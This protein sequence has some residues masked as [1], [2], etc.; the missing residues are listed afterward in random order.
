MIKKPLRLLAVIALSLLACNSKSTSSVTIPAN[1][2][3]NLESA[4]VQNA[5]SAPQKQSTGN[6]QRLVMHQFRDGNGD[7][8]S[9]M[10][11]PADWQQNNGKSKGQ[12][13][14][15]G[16]HGL[17]ITD[18]QGRNFM[19]TNDPRMQQV[20]YRSGQQL[21]AMPGIEQVIQQDIVPQCTGQ[22]L[23]FVRYYELEEVTKIDKWYNDQLYKAVPSQMELE[24]IGTDWKT[25]DGDPYFLIIHFSMS[26]TAELQMW[27][28]WCTGLEAEKSY[29]P[30]AQKQLLFGLSNTHYPLGPIMVYNR[31]EAEKAGQSWAAFNQ[32][33]AQN[34][35]AFEA[36]QREHVNRTNAINDAIMSGWNER[37]AASDKQ[38]ERTIDGIYER[39]NAVDPSNGQRYKV[40][41]GSNQYWMN[42]NG[43]YIGSNR[44]DYNPNLDDNM[45]NVKW[46]E[47]NEVK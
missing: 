45:N 4:M 9:E 16:P 43:E 47:L 37:N 20:Y 33:M 42:S 23:Q 24:A 11:F 18:Y 25:A 31:R 44:G 15:T 35:A 41:A 10:P 28:Y 29:F 7:V 36:N 26:T 40:S 8:T 12:P 13:T 5:Q 22:G 34:Q 46:Q 17:K 27:S 19:Y 14:F 6:W 32:R 2:S 39:T 3:I 30:M 21:R 1:D 38:Q